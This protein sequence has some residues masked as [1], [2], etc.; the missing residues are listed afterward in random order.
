MR[1]SGRALQH[2]AG[3]LSL[4]CG[5]VVCPA[6]CSEDWPPAEM[7]AAIDRGPRRSALLPEAIECV[8]KEAREK[9]AQGCACIV[10][11]DNIKD[12]PPKR[13]KIHPLSMIPHNSRKFRAILDLSFRLRL[14]GRGD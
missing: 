10:R 6:D 14:T 12:A 2:S 11:W 5:T 3:A 4:Q 8:Q 1:P 13:L 9:A 7:Q